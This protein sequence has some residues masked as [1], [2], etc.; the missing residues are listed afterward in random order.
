MPVDDKPIRRSS[1]AKQGDDDED[2]M[3][4]DLADDAVWK[5]I[6]QNTFTRY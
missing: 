6:Q 3:E 1:K 2:I 5:R 4:K